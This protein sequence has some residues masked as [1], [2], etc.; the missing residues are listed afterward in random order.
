M[1]DSDKINAKLDEIEGR[2]MSR[3]MPAWAGTDLMNTVAALLRA[4]RYADQH[5]GRGNARYVLR[6]DIAK[7]LG[8]QR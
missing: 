2:R 4:L 5:S 6:R 1:S 3:D 8:I 7:I